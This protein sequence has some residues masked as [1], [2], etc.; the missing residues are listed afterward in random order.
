MT[1]QIE[2]REAELHAISCPC[3]RCAEFRERREREKRLGRLEDEER[4]RA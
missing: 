1:E 4:E 3:E 2:P